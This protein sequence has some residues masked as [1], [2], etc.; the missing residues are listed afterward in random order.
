MDHPGRW[1]AMVAKVPADARDY[2]VEGPGGILKNAPPWERPV[3]EPSK[4]RLT[5]P[6]GSWATIYSDEE[7]EALRGFS[8]DTAWIDELAKFRNAKLSWDNL[9][10][11]MREASADRPRKMITTTP[12]P[13]KIMKEIQSLK[14]TVTVIGS[15]YENRSNLDPEWFDET[16][17]VYEGTRFGRQEIYADELEEADG[18]LWTRDMT[19][20]CAVKEYPE[21]VRIVVA[22]DPAATKTSTSDEV[23]LMVGGLDKNGVGYLLEDLSA[24]LSPGETSKVACDAYDLW[25]ADR[26]VAEANNG[27]D[28]IELGLRQYKPGISYKKLHASRGKAARAEPIAALYEQNRI[29]HVGMFPLLEDELCSWEPNSGL[30][31]PN[32]LDALVWLFYELML[33]KGTMRKLHVR[34]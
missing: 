24:K 29:K 20:R 34:I 6:N 5:W 33:S 16:L 15:S 12:K 8:G 31:S 18:A 23:G 19:E 28:W 3:Y 4:R 32:R 13:L 26:V 21:L 22:I 17:S 30:P 1:I 10:F 2:M 27:G 11:G 25:E 7:P 9:A 14:S